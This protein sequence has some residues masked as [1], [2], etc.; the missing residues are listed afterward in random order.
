MDKEE[1]FVNKRKAEDCNRC[2]LVHSIR[3]NL[4][5]QALETS[6]SLVWLFACRVHTPYMCDA[7]RVRVCLCV[8]VSAATKIH[9][10]VALATS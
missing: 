1:L 3:I 5:R 4:L 9:L 6:A 10:N 7:E 8:R 2:S